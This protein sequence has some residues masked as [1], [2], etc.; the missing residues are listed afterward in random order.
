MPAKA[1]Q[2]GMRVMGLTTNGAGEREHSDS[3]RHAGAGEAETRQWRRS[4]TEKSGSIR[5]SLGGAAESV[6]NSEGLEGV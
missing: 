5:W 6:V 2:L 1:H 3:Q 4:E